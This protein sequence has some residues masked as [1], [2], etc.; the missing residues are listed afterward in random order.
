VPRSIVTNTTLDLPPAGRIG[1]TQSKHPHRFPATHSLQLLVT[2]FNISP[3]AHATDLYPKPTK[4]QHQSAITKANSKHI[5]TNRHMRLVWV[6]QHTPCGSCRNVRRHRQQRKRYTT[7]CITRGHESR[8][9]LL[10]KVE[11]SLLAKIDNGRDD[12]PNY[13]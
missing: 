1:S 13:S 8:V 9:A 2:L 7:T 10:S 4:H 6:A 12:F 3:G 5:L 11:R